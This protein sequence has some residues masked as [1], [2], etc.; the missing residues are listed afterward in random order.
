MMHKLTLER[1]VN[2]TGPV[3]YGLAL[4]AVFVEGFIFIFLSLIGMRQWLVKLIPES[5]KLASSVGIGL[6]LT[7]I[8][9]SYSGGIGAISGG[10]SIPLQI[11]GCLPIYQNQTTGVCESHIMTSPTARKQSYNN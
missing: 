7:T 9:L 4:T 6:F 11:A 10:T 3:P 8:G 5:V 2:G 1:G